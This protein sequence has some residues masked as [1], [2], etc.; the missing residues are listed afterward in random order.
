[1]SSPEKEV[2][3]RE[4]V[5]ADAGTFAGFMR[6]AWREAGPE[7]PGFAGAT[8]ESIAEITSPDTFRRT[9]GGPERRMFLA[10][11]GQD[12]VGF[13]ATRREDDTTVELSGI[14]VLASYA[15]RGIGTMLV[16]A[17]VDAAKDEEYTAVLVKTETTNHRARAFYENLGFELEGIGAE[18]VDG[19]AVEVWKLL[20]R[21]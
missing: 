16:E 21:L 13:A 8:D 6:R 19:A 17:A 1:M 7:A 4:A 20:L 15:G 14:V 9:I 5:A 11:H 2:Q 18:D 10:W 3:V 12:V